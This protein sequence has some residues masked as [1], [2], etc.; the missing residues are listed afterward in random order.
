MNELYYKTAD[1]EFKPLSSIESVTIEA[2]DEDLEKFSRIWKS[3]T[4]ECTFQ[5]ENPEEFE[6]QVIYGGDKGRYFKCTK[7]GNGYRLFT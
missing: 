2:S 3:E 5:I 1:G 6:K 7:R 4:L